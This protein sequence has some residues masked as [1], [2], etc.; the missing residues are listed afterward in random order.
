MVKVISSEETD[1]ILGV[2]IVGSCASELI[3]QALVAIEFGASSEDIG[4]MMFGHPTLSE[5]F[6]EAALD[7]SGSAIH[8]FRGKK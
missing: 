8:I 1:R 6:R 4:M 3:M 5:A 7:V 2:H